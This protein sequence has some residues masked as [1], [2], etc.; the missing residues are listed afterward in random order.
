MV[1][2]CVSVGISVRDE[3][4]RLFVLVGS[5]R[6]SCDGEDSSYGC[7]AVLFAVLKP[8]NLYPIF[9]LCFFRHEWMSE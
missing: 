5:A 8:G 2:L 7:C 9:Q 4:E 6:G 1:M 3:C